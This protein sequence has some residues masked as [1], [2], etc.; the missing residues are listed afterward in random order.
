MSRQPIILNIE[1]VARSVHEVNRAYCIA[2]GDTSQVA[3]ESAPE[4]QIQSVVSNVLAVLN[5]ATPKKLHDNWVK[6]KEKSGWK[7]GPTKDPAKKEHPCLVPYEQLSDAD[8][9]KDLLFHGTVKLVMKTLATT[10]K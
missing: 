6:D 5:G 7:Y 2:I 4:W 1:A 3:W 10:I 8:K 9:A